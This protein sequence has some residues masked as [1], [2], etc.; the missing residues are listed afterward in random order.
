MADFLEALPRML[1]GGGESARLPQRARQGKI[2]SVRPP[3]GIHFLYRE[4][5]AFPVS[6]RKSHILA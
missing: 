6:H 5:R 4:R 3:N 2:P 1:R